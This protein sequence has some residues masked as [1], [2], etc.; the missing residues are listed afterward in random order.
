MLGKGTSDERFQVPA[1]EVVERSFRFVLLATN[2]SSYVPK[3][4]KRPLIPISA[5]T[6]RTRLLYHFFDDS[7]PSP[8]TYHH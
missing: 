3:C 5:V 2:M 1:K 6:S 4:A 7:L 8:A